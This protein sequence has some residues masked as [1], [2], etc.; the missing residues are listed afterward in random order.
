[1]LIVTNISLLKMLM[2]MMT[3]ASIYL[4]KLR[5]MLINTQDCAQYYVSDGAR[6][7]SPED[8]CKKNFIR[9]LKRAGEMRPYLQHV[10]FGR[11]EWR[12]MSA[13]HS[14]KS[15]LVE[16]GHQYYGMP[17]I[18]K[19]VYYMNG[20]SGGWNWAK[21]TQ[22]DLISLLKTSKVGLHVHIGTFC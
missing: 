22:D 10:Q 21:A 18:L 19:I 13:L 14:W 20:D 9:F 16:H 3:D 2:D 12:R 15:T 8:G 7:A 5:V 1:M 4:H 11:Q 6:Y 17:R